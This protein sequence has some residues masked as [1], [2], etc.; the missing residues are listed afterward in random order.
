MLQSLVL[1]MLVKS[2]RLIRVVYLVG[3]MMQVEVTVVI[4]YLTQQQLLYDELNFEVTLNKQLPLM[5]SLPL[6]IKHMLFK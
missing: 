2:E 1:V 6:Q 4:L 3:E 5:M